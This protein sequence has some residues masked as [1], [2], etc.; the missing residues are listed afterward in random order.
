MVSGWDPQNPLGT[1]QGQSTKGAAGLGGIQTSPS[2][3]TKM[4]R[5]MPAGTLRKVRGLGPARAG[6][7]RE[8][9]GGWQYLL[10]KPWTLSPGPSLGAPRRLAGGGKAEVM[11]QTGLSVPHC[12]VAP[13][14]QFPARRQTAGGRIQNVQG[15]LPFYLDLFYG[16]KNMLTGS[17]SKHARVC[18]ERGRSPSPVNTGLHGGR[19]RRTSLSSS[20]SSSEAPNTLEFLL[21]P[22]PRG[23]HLLPSLEAILVIGWLA[24]GIFCPPAAA[25]RAHCA[26]LEKFC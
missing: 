11:V 17:K 23:S 3:C 4:A 19:G 14:P 8:G 2:L 25:H 24:P 22:C 6:G 9:F 5:E 7:R 26:A 16:S 10:W 15:H 12:R 1:A 21:Y 20:A 18:K 13:L